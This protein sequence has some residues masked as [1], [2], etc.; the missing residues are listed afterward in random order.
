MTVLSNL[1]AERVFSEH[2][3]SLWALDDEADYISLISESD[4]RLSESSWVKTNANVAVLSNTNQELPSYIPFKDSAINQ[5]TTTSTASTSTFSKSL[6]FDSSDINYSIGTFSVAT[7]IYLLSSTAE[8]TISYSAT[9]PVTSNSISDSQV[10]NILDA[11]KWAFV[12]ATFE[13]PGNAINLVLNISIKYNSPVSG[14]KY[15]INGLSIG[16]AAEVFQQ[17]SLGHSVSNLTNLSITGQTGISAATYGT[18]ATPG[19]YLSE[20]GLL[21]ATNSSM[22]LVHGSSS[23]TRLIRNSFGPSLIVPGD[24]FLNEHGKHRDL[25]LEAWIRIKAYVV[26]DAKRIIGPIASDDGVYVNDAFITLRIGSKSGSYPI[27]EWD[28]P[29]LLAIRLSARVA[30]LVINGEEVITLKLSESDL[31]YPEK[32]SSTGKEQDWIGFYCHEDVPYLEVDVVG[33]YPYLVP[34]VVEKRR[35]VFG[36]GVGLPPETDGT[37]IAST[38]AIDYPSSKY[39]KNYLYPDIGKFSQGINENLSITERDISL[40]DYTLPETVFSNKASSDWIAENK[41]AQDSVDL[42][43]ISMKPNQYW[44]NTEGYINFNQVN[45]IKQKIKAFYGF[46]KYLDSETRQTLFYIKNS[47]T[48]DHFEIFIEDGDVHYS[49]YKFSEGSTLILNSKPILDADEYATVGIDIDKFV[50]TYGGNLPSFF[51]NRQ[52]L[53]VYVAGSSELKDTF[54]GRIY[55]VGFLTYR[56]FLKISNVFSAPDGTTVGYLEF[57]ALN[58]KDAKGF[59][60]QGQTS[61]VTDYTASDVT[62]ADGGSSYFGNSSSSFAEIYDGGTV[63]SVMADVILSHVASYTLVPK[64]FIGNFFLDIAVNGYWQDYIPM[65]YLAKKVTDG[66]NVT[67]NSLDFVQFN[68]SYPEIKSFVNKTYNTENAIVRTYVSFQDLKS[69]TTISPLVTEIPAPESGVIYPGAEWKTVKYEIVDNC[70]IYPPS[71]I[72]IKTTGLVLHVELL[73]RGISETPVK[74]KSIQVASQALNAKSSNPVGTKYGVDIYPLTNTALYDDYK[75]RNPYSIYK[76]STPHLYLTS[77]SGISL[78]DITGDSTDR[79]I[80]IPINKTGDIQAAISG[81]QLSVNFVQ[82]RFPIHPVMIF[83]IESKATA[84]KHV[85][86]FIVSDNQAGSRGRVYG[87]DAKTGELFGGIQYFINGRLVRQPVLDINTWTTIG[88]SFL[89]ILDFSRRQGAVR[90]AGPGLYNNVSIYTTSMAEAARRVAYRKW[91]GVLDGHV[92]D[93]W[94]TYTWQNVLF[95]SEEGYVP[96]SGSKIYGKY[97]GTNRFIVDDDKYL[98]AGQYEYR[99]YTGISW[100]VNTAIPV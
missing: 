90:L 88:F 25:T 17:S 67:R 60:V 54:T 53:S 76:G 33:I 6:S 46:F 7:Y 73:S 31:A 45:I 66:N 81:F 11:S 85:K 77:K 34:A 24:G 30:T 62:V 48:G 20:G 51:G 58:A 57:E 50:S 68:V 87:I 74:I 43:F 78:R 36:Q 42:P 64:V 69:T 70:I 97:T 29:M 95:I 21:C 63:Y 39:A 96:V 8:L 41:G 61:S 94:D 26:S 98:I 49:F 3:I 99:A 32:Y 71:D 44:Q 84:G 47:Q 28:R 91:S 9:D 5:I 13:L 52:N 79:K 23:S 75:T 82:E 10:F 19:Y 93:D 18:N 14:Y 38:I 37:S 56:N 80:S 16:Q 1:Y 86:F 15:F 27:S 40:P 65:S 12:S 4:R 89:E 92:W 59:Y 83:E 35:W 72:D 2:P 55:R 100:Q 22:P